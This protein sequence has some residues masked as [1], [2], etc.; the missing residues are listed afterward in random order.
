MTWPEAALD[1]LKTVNRG[2]IELRT[3]VR[4]LRANMGITDG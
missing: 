1:E 4:E 3:A 2:L